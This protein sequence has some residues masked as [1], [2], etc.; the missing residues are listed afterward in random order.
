MSI[1]IQ[2]EGILTTVQDTG[3]IGYRR[4]GINTSGA[5]DVSAVRLI[6]TLLGNNETEAVLEMHFPAPEILF[7]DSAVFAVGGADFA[8]ELNN[9]PIENWKPYF[10]ETGG[11]LRF[12][13]KSFGNRAYLSV[14]GGFDLDKWLGSASTNLTAKIGG[15][16]GRR[17]QKN[18]K[19]LFKNRNPK[20]KR[21]NFKLSNEV[22][23]FYS[24]FPTV[25][26]I[27]GA[28][29]ESLNAY[30]EQCLLHN[31]FTVS[32]NSDRMGY[33]LTGEPLYL[34]D[35][36]E[37][38]SSAVNFGTI[39]LLPEG[40]MIILMADCQTSGGYPR[41]AHIIE[42]DLP[43]VAQLGTNDKIAFQLISLIEAENILLDF[44]KDLQ[45]LKI[46]VNYSSN[47]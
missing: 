44:K 22:I 1:S 15:F 26:I 6:N 47:F 39:Q 36:K 30:S 8:G 7:E 28:E 29:F 40:Q 46:G 25:R 2:K 14:K 34:L 42:I 38:V 19:L 24:R 43:L 17:L 41:I 23:P 21:F 9:E 11:V 37:L 27:E 33:R 10:A 45:F 12:T 35:K 3:R 5:M 18:D 13:G 32:Q 31:N 16:S 4:F 20:A